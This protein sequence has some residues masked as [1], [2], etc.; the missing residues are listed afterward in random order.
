[1]IYTYMTNRETVVAARQCTEFTFLLL[2]ECIFIFFVEFVLRL[3][4]AIEWLQIKIKQTKYWNWYTRCDLE[5][6][7]PGR[8]EKETPP[9]SKVDTNSPE[10]GITHIKMHMDKFRWKSIVVLVVFSS[11]PRQWWAL[12]ILYFF[13]S[14]CLPFDSIL[15][16]HLTNMLF[17]Q[18]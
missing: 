10:E 8:S 16:F 7:N 18:S 11:C 15:S 5:S 12:H 13:I 4:N 14:F 17:F 6:M 3:W 1:M 2:I 9:K